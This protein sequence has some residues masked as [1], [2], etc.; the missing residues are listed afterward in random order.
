MNLNASML[1]QAISFVIFVWLCMKYVWPPL[2]AMLDERQKMIAD[3]LRH[4][5]NAAK[6]LDIAK[7]N[8]ADLVDEA[9]RNVSE[10]LEQ[11]NKRRNEIITQAQQDAEKEKARI[12]E[13]G[14]AELEGERQKIRQELQ[15]QMAD[16]VIESAQKLIN[17]NLDSDANRALVDQLIKEI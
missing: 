1:G 5:E 7:A 10:L 6:E 3:G 9:K 12:L 4:S 16:A 17:K 13:Q 8:A 11:G 15:A 14:R 2:T